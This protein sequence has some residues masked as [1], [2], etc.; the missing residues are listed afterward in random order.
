MHATS[1]LWVLRVNRKGSADFGGNVESQSTVDTESVKHC[2]PKT[3][4]FGQ[5]H[6]ARSTVTLLNEL[7]YGD[8]KTFAFGAGL[9]LQQFARDM[10][11]L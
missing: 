5:A 3:R 8:E 7:N 9:R 2:F 10:D 11:V 6:P 4:N 1:S